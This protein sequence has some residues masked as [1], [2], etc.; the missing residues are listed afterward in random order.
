MLLK[1]NPEITAIFAIN[2]NIA[3]SSIRAA[4]RLGLDVPDD[5][6]VIGYDDTDLATSISPQL[7]T[8][9]VDTVAMGQGAAHLVSM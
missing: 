5:V 7:T 6:S 1:N 9:H 4:Q 3:V 8:M 2:D